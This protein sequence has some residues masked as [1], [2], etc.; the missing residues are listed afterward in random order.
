MANKKLPTFKP[1]AAITVRAILPE[2]RL[3]VRAARWPSLKRVTVS[4][5]A[6]GSRKNSKY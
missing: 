4:S 1:F 6:P 2:D 3:Q 5:R